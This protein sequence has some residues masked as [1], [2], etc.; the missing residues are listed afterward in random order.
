MEKGKDPPTLESC[1]DSQSP[2]VSSIFY[3]ALELRAPPQGSLRS[4]KP[5]VLCLYQPQ[6][7]FSLPE[8]LCLSL[9]TMVSNSLSFKNYPS[10][11]SSESHSRSCSKPLGTRLGLVP[12][13]GQFLP[14]PSLL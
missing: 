1:L 7:C 5:A 12:E 4:F 10:A 3:L 6:K 8:P 2:Q 14:P 11:P 13:A 9:V